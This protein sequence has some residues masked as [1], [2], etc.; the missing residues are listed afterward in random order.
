MKLKNTSQVPDRVLR[1]M[2]AWV[3]RKYGLP[4]RKIQQVEASSCNGGIKGR[5]SHHDGKRWNLSLSICRDIRD[6]NRDLV[7]TVTWYI[8]HI[9]GRIETGTWVRQGSASREARN[10]SNEFQRQESSLLNEW[11]K[12][13]LRE[14]VKTVE[15]GQILTP[16][17][18]LVSMKT[19]KTPKKKTRK[20]TNAERAAKNLKNWERKL[21][22]AST[23]V[24][25]Y[26]H[27]VKRYQREGVLE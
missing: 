14:P 8:A 27:Q 15:V 26:R 4:V 1:R 13:D 17:E 11:H 25:K 16:E 20:Q 12:P 23:K 5:V 7:Y 21:K 24:K 22:L 18:L 10:M 19:R 2:I 3:C 6:A 9:Q